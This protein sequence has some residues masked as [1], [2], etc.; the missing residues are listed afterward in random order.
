M[1]KWLASLFV[2]Q[3]NRTYTIQRPK[4]ELHPSFCLRVLSL[5]ATCGGLSYGEVKQIQYTDFQKKSHHFFAH[6]WTESFMSEPKPRIIL[7]SIP[8]IQLDCLPAP[9]QVT[10]VAL[11]DVMYSSFCKY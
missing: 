6:S 4:K 5:S 3:G 11:N 9:A 1:D 8:R 10:H 2:P 7:R